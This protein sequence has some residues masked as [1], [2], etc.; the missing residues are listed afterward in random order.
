MNVI[1]D[2]KD[3]G[4][5]ERFSVID[6]AQVAMLRELASADARLVVKGGMAMRLVVGSLRLTKAIDFDRAADISSASVRASV[7]KAL[8]YGAQ[9]ASLLGH[10]VDELKVTETTVRM[11]LSGNLAGTPVKFVV[12]VSGRHKLPDDCHAR[13]TVTPHVGSLPSRLERARYVA[14]CIARLERGE[15]L[16]NVY[17]PERGY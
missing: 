3:R 8:V 13:I 4:F 9:S 1:Y 5:P 6:R 15:A 17:D 14:D 12:E 16:P 11:R 2:P 7:R 10:Q